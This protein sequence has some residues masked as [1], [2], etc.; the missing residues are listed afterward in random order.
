MFIS[1]GARYSVTEAVDV[2][3]AYY[4]YRQ[5]NYAPSVVNAAAWL[6]S[7]NNRSF[8]AG[9][10]MHRPALFTSPLSRPRA[11][12]KRWPRHPAGSTHG[13]SHVPG[14]AANGLTN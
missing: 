12:R 6:A 9:R 1:A 8:C 11:E 10:I 13:D 4:H 5:N 2:I 3:D 14:G 7:S